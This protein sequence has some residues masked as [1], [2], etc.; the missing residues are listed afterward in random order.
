MPRSGTGVVG[1]ST[2]KPQL[3]LFELTAIAMMKRL[4]AGFR[5]DSL[6]H[7]GCGSGRPS[8]LTACPSSAEEGSKEVQFPRGGY[9]D[10]FVQ[11]ATLLI[12]SCLDGRCSRRYLHLSPWGQEGFHESSP[13]ASRGCH[14][15]SDHQF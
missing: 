4:D 11:L 2:R 14:V 3:S 6:H 9:V 12:K 13:F 7:P 5:N 15:E 10:L 1:G 8:R